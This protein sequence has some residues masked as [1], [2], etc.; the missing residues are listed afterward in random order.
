MSFIVSLHIPKTA[1]TS[2]LMA[3]QTAFGDRLV[4]YNEDP[5]FIL[6]S[7]RND[8]QTRF[9]IVHGHLNAAALD[10]VMDKDAIVVTFLRDPVQ[11]VL[12][13]YFFHKNPET[14]N[15]L[16][17]KVRS[18]SMSLEEFADM[19]GQRNLQTKMIAPV[20]RDR[21]DFIGISE[22]FS[23]SLERLSDILP[24]RL[25][26][27]KSLNVNKKKSVGGT[28]D[29]DSKTRDFIVNRNTK[30]IELYQSVCDSF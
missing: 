25:E 7:S 23:T 10:I 9:D 5:K 14:K 30:D 24:I 21:L 26:L 12:S 28:Y 13:S 8:I 20:G 2:L 3:Y 4:Q 15:V 27:P 11:R 1:G 22:Q 6:A 18:Q 16:G 29:I 19:P 17:E